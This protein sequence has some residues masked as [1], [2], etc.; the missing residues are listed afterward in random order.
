MGE[1]IFE[2]LPQLY[3]KFTL[4]L[5]QVYPSRHFSIDFRHDIIIMRQVIRIT[6]MKSEPR[7]VFLL[8]KNMFLFRHCVVMNAS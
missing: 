1:K 8:Q 7:G 3:P 4:I 2:S 5:P 6:E